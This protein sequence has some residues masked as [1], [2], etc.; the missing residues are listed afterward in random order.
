MKGRSTQPG[1]LTPA[2][3]RALVILR[4]HGPIRPREFARLMWPDSGGWTRSAKCGVKGAHRG[5]GMYGAAGAYLGKLWHLRL[6][7][8][9]GIHAGEHQL[10]DLGRAALEAAEAAERLPCVQ[11]P[12]TL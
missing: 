11:N 6:S 9:N 12:V 5:G 10:T 1:P 4:D 2:Q 3:R 8:R 7:R